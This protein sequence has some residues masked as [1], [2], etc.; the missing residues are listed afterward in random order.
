[1]LKS[2]GYNLAGIARFRG[3][4]T[5]ET[6]WPYALLLFVLALVACALVVVPTVLEGAG[7]M[8]RFA[9]EHPELATIQQGPGS[10]SIQIH[11][12]HPELMPDL[13]GAIVAM[14]GIAL[15]F[16]LLVAAAVTRR[17]HDRGLSGVL[18]LLPVLFLLIGLA[19]LPGLMDS[20]RAAPEKINGFLLLFAN[21]LLYLA[22]LAGLGLLLMLRGTAGPNRY[23][24]DPTPP[25][26]RLRRQSPPRPRD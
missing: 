14:A 3:R 26:T 13:C 8:Q 7:R 9:I 16:V 10:Y 19:L 12:R 23:G 4:D 1:M 22:S 17:L 6:F 2:I 11:G 5:R 21:N 15:V 18:G 24:A 25:E 20:A